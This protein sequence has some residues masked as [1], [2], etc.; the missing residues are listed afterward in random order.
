MTVN[1]SGLEKLAGNS[2]GA[3]T[4]LNLKTNLYIGGVGPKTKIAA[5][6]QVQSGF[7]GC[8]SKVWKFYFDKKKCSSTNFM[9][10]KNKKKVKVKN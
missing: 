6:A 9:K 5:A 3:M 10:L 2:S 7:D 4:K 1:N 8:I